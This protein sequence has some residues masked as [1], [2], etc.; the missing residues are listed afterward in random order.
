MEHLQRE[1]TYF[2]AGTNSIYVPQGRVKY[3]DK[4]VCKPWFDL[5][6]QSRLTAPGEAVRIELTREWPDLK[7]VGWSSK[8]VAL[9]DWR[10]PMFYSGPYVGPMIYV[11]LDAAYSQIY[12]K[13]WLDTTYPRGYY[14]QY[15][16]VKVAERLKGWKTARNSLIGICRSR[17]GVAY[18]G[19]RRISIKMKNRYLSPGLWAT[20][21]TILHWIASEALKHDAIYVNVDGY[22]FPG[23]S[24]LLTDNFL[25]KL[26]EW[27]FRWSI[28]AQGQGE[29]VS[30]NN[31]RIGQTRTQANR[32]NLVQNSK[33]FSNVKR[34]SQRRWREYWE[35]V[36]RIHGNEIDT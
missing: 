17:E 27:G 34:N 35:G 6:G 21:Q 31:Y 30:W 8:Q 25:F 32:L 28:R 16:L 2:I 19:T 36:R 3:L 11:D 23:N 14:G 4:A 12:E 13:L 5:D 1:G 29:I 22:I 9:F 18:R 24:E 10:S 20:V 33:E 15:P 26:S 7:R